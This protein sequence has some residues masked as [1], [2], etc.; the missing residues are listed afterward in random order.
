MKVKPNYDWGVHFAIEGK[1]LQNIPYTPFM[2]GGVFSDTSYHSEGK[3]RND[4]IVIFQYTLSGSCIFRYN[5]TEHE[6]PAGSGFLCFANDPKMSYR[7]NEKSDQDYRHI[8][9]AITGNDEFFHNLISTYGPIYRMDQVNKW[10]QRVNAN[11]KDTVKNGWI[12]ISFEENVSMTSDL[13]VDILGAGRIGSTNLPKEGKLISDAK[14]ILNDNQ[15]HH[16]SVTALAAT[17]KITPQHLTR[18][19]KEE[20]DLTATQLIDMIKVD[21][22]K[23]LLKFGKVNVKEIA[24]EIGFSNYNSFL[25]TFKR[26]T[27]IS[28]VRF[29][30]EL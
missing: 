30:K 1:V 15:G 24:F 4:N 5:E 3:N 13:I 20:I 18:K 25:R 2:G 28:P 7:Y 12:K 22:A 17:L 26:V 10:F 6:V 16:F 23:L 8:Y 19:C 21:Q 29:K 11:W 9:M 27:G 14:R